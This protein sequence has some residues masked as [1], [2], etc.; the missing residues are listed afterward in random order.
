MNIIQYFDFDSSSVRT[1]QK[2]DGSI[3]FCLADCLRAIKSKTQ[4]ADAI[5]SIE[6][7]FGDGVVIN[8]PIADSLGR[9]QDTVFIAEPGLTLLLSRSRTETGKKLNRFLHSEVLPSIRKTGSY[10]LPSK[11]NDAPSIPHHVLASQVV[12]TL[13]KIDDKL[14]HQPRLAQILRD[15][16]MNSIVEQPLLNG[17]VERLRGVAE[18]ATE[19]GYKIDSSNR[20]KLGQ[21]IKANGFS[22]VKESRICN[23]VDTLINCYKDNL[24]LRSAISA[25]FDR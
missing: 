15:F 18:I 5:L 22:S 3:W 21:Y 4:T 23:G 11:V 10:S 24:A 16:A 7:T 17:N 25:F 9:E 2:D 19:M 1:I 6:E 14:S 20:V 13:A 12:D 8:V